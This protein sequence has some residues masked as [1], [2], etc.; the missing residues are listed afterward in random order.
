M[1]PQTFESY[2]QELAGIQGAF[3]GAYKEDY[4]DLFDK[5]LENKDV[6]QIMEYAQ[7]WGDI[8]TF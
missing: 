2:L 7:N 5:W 6:P 1:K 4:E 3:D 8:I